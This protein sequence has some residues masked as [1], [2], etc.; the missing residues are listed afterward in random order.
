VAEPAD[1]VDERPHFRGGPCPRGPYTERAHHVA[2]HV[3]QSYCTAPARGSRKSCAAHCADAATAIVAQ[4]TVAAP[5]QATTGRV[6]RPLNKP[7][8]KRSSQRAGSAAKPISDAA[9]SDGH[10]SASG[11]SEVLR[12]IIGF[13]GITGL[14]RALA[15]GLQ[16]RAVCSINGRFRALSRHLSF[17][18][19][20]QVCS[21]PVICPA[22]CKGAASG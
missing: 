7:S 2:R 19:D 13:C 4:H 8:A 16:T 14:S 12:V 6:K 1:L 10:V 15:G 21:K 22:L 5:F 11:Q 20:E 18:H 3:S 9:G 17:D